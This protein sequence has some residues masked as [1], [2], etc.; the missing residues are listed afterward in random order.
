LSFLGEV[1]NF[2]EPASPESAIF[3]SA[4]ALKRSTRMY[5]RYV[6]AGYEAELGIREKRVRSIGA[7]W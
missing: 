6:K 2:E 7:W 5:K 4:S 3:I 1:N